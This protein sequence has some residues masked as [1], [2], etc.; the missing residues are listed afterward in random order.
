[1]GKKQVFRENTQKAV[2]PTRHEKWT[3]FCNCAQGTAEHEE[4]QGQGA[5][6]QRIRE[7]GP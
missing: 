4:C 7:R 6:R 3:F 1:M 2:S 5:H